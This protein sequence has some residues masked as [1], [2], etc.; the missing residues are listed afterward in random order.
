MPE[1]IDKELAAIN[2]DIASAQSAL[3]SKGTEELIQKAREEAR[4]EAEKEFLV[5]QRIKEIETQKA[6]LQK[7]LEDKEKASAEE[8]DKLKTKVNE[9]VSSRA[10]IQVQDPFRNPVNTGQELSEEKITQIEV[11]SAR[12]FW[13][14]DAYDDML[15]ES[16]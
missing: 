16:K 8:L 10:S 13:G 6:E 2:A 1:E 11:A 3:V 9:L 15:R 12:A 5:N 4:K 7:R 14:D